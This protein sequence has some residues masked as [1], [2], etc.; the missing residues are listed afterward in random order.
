V[1]EQTSFAWA[2]GN[3]EANHKVNADLCDSH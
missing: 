1:A 2:Q 3:Q